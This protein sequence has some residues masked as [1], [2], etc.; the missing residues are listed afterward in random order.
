MGL[1]ECASG[2]PNCNRCQ[3]LVVNIES[4]GSGATSHGMARLH[5]V[6]VTPGRRLQALEHISQRPATI[7]ILYE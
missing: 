2:T 3:R 4:S 1:G 7:N 6:V 5:R